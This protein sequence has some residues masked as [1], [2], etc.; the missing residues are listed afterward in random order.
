[1]YGAIGFRHGSAQADNN[2]RHYRWCRLDHKVKKV[3]EVSDEVYAIQVNIFW[4]TLIFPTYSFTVD[5]MWTEVGRIL[6]VKDI[7]FGT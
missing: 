2:I 3:I 5:L 1:M 7:V 6:T 4:E